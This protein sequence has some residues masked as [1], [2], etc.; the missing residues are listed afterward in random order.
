MLP[1]TAPDFARLFHAYGPAIDTPEHLAALTGDDEDAQ[2]RAV[3]HLWSAVLHQG[4]PGTV[5]P[6]AVRAVVA[7]LG[8]TGGEAARGEAGDEERIVA[9]APSQVTDP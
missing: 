2:V 8:G 6:V 7:A 4:T 5:T 9:S 3:R 1:V